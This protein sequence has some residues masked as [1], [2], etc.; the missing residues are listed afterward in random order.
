MQHSQR[1][2]YWVFAWD[3]LRKS[4]GRPNADDTINCIASKLLLILSLPK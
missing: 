3:Q 4:T 1:Y 2:L